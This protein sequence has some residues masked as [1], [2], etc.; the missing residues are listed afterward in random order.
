MQTN[1]IFGSFCVFDALQFAS[2]F[3]THQPTHHTKDNIIVIYEFA[4]EV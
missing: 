2:H 4:R 1:P 3:S